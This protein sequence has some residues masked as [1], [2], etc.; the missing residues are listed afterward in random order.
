ME[1]KEKF[2][3]AIELLEG[4]IET[5]I[6]C[7]NGISYDDVESFKGT[8]ELLVSLSKVHNYFNDLKNDID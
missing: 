7:M 8:S 5:C 1:L 2:E 6:E 4:E 3:I